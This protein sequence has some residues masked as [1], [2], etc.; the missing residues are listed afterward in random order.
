MDAG[1]VIIE[2]LGAI[3]GLAAIVGVVLNNR[4]LI[5]CFYVWIFSNALT[6]GIHVYSGLWTLAI[7]DVVFLVLAFDGLRHWRR[8]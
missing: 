7:R 5:G 8:S 4:R 6:G 2:V 1:Q 3:A